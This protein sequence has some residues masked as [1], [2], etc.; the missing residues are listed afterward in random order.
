MIPSLESVAGTDG[1]NGET[2]LL[3]LL[4][5][6]DESTV[7]DKGRSG[8]V[9][10]DYMNKRY[11]LTMQFCVPS[12]QSRVLNS[13]HSVRITTA[14]ASLQASMADLAILK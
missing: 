13:S 5:V 7:K 8:A 6:E 2:D 14:S 11:S 4:S 1:D 3:Q 9:V 10:V 12:C